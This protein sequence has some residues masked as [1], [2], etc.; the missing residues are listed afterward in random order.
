MSSTCLMFVEKLQPLREFPLW[1]SGNELSSIHE[2]PGSTLAL[3]SQLRILH[4]HELWYSSQRWLRSCVAVAVTQASSYSSDSTPSLGSSICH[5][6]SPKKTKP[7]KQKYFSLPLVPK[8]KLSQRSE[9]MQK[10]RIIKQDDNGWPSK[11][12]SSSSRAIGNI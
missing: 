9:Q 4:C 5:E 2:D 7:K 12:F 1:L 10:P 8:N 3:L 6:Y 11:P